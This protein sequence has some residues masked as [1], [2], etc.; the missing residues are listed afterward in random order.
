MSRSADATL[1]ST[2]F[3]LAALALPL[4]A[5]GFEEPGFGPP[6]GPIVTSTWSVGPATPEEGGAATFDVTIEVKIGGDYHIYGLAGTFE[7]ENVLATSF[8]LVDA[9]GFELVGLPTASRTPDIK[10]DEFVGTYP[11]WEKEIT[12][13]QKV[14]A[15]AFAANEPASFKLKSEWM[16]CNDS[17]CLP[18]EEVE[19]TLQTPSEVS[20]PPVVQHTWS[21]GPAVLH[22]DGSAVFEVEVAIKVG[23]D[24]HIYGLDGT[25]DNADVW[26]TKF[27]LGKDVEAGIRLEGATQASREPTIKPADG[28]IR[29]YPYFAGEVTFTQKIRVQDFDAENPRP[30][31]FES[32]WMACNDDGCLPFED[33]T[34]EFMTPKE[35]SAARP[36]FADLSAKL[37]D[38]GLSPG[39]PGLLLVQLSPEARDAIAAGEVRSVLVVDAPVEVAG[40]WTV[41]GDVLRVPIATQSESV[42]EGEYT[43]RGAILL[44]SGDR[45]PFGGDIDISRSILAFIIFAAAAALLALLTPCVFPMIPIT[46]SFFTK[47]AESAHVNPK[48]MGFVYGVGIVGSFTLIGA[49]FTLSLGAEGATDFATHPI[50]LG[51]IG[52]LF[53]LFALSLFGAFELQLPSGLMQ[54]A[55]GAQGKGGILGVWLLGTLFAITTFTCTAPFVGG[56]LAGAAASGEWTRPILG[57][58]VF[59]G[60]LAVPFI[61][62]AIFPSKLKS[63]PKSGGWLNEVKVIMGFIELMAAFKFFGD[64]G[65]T[66]QSDT[67]SR[68]LILLVWIV[69]LVMMGLYI[70]GIIRLP[71]DSPREKASVLGLLL[72]MSCFLGAFSLSKGLDGSPLSPDVEAYL[73]REKAERTPEGRERALIDRLLK[74]MPAVAAPATDDGSTASAAGAGASKWKVPT[75][76]NEAKHFEYEVVNHLENARKLAIEMKRPLFLDFTGYSCPNCRKFER[77]VFGDPRIK[78]LVNE[79]FVVATLYTDGKVDDPVFQKRLDSQQE[80]QKKKFDTVTNPHYAVVDPGSDANADPM[81][82]SILKTEGYNATYV[83]D[84]ALFV[85]WLNEAHAKYL[86]WNGR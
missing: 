8:A 81:D 25:F 17:G 78:K 27:S 18:P 79:K 9:D 19:K 36:V 11:Y 77:G 12:F 34:K 32:T 70:L 55:G 72:A 66:L 67:F 30:F 54:L 44:T 1:F 60:V 5:Q 35:V 65:G 22:A 38:D 84:P 46:V 39:D 40:D 64:M 43:F 41:D 51:A 50:T 47:Q 63:L 4:P 71:K 21:V 74:A 49:I 13:V 52:V 28:L 26:P 33:V 61:F 15:K 24:Y 83:D 59:S 57:M 53:V 20:E 56:L 73:P 80:L 7:N 6:G 14:R 42:D 68:Q 76:G 29:E 31:V 16:A 62:L 10:V 82:M 45:I 58:L 75:V 69:C 48:I 37:E 85:A 2:L 86:E 3:L 23:G